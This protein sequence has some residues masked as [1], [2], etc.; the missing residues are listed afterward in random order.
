M[1]CLLIVYKSGGKVKDM[2]RYEFEKRVD[3]ILED[4]HWQLAYSGNLSFIKDVKSRDR[5]LKK[6]LRQR[7]TRK[8]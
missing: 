5:F 2:V 4:G 6:I 3:A 8:S 1:A 7:R